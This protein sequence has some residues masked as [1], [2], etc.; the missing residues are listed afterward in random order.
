LN[1]TIQELHIVATVPE[2][3]NIV[4]ELNSVQSI[5]QLLSHDN[6]GESYHRCTIIGIS[7]HV[8]SGV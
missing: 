7:N 8:I 6:T 3:Y 2:L 1:D 5:L 4:T